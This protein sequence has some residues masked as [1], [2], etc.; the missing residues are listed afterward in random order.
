[1]VVVARGRLDDLRDFRVDGAVRHPLQGLLH[2]APRL[3]PL[4]EAYEVTVVRVAVLADGHLEVHVCVGGVRPRLAYVPSDARAPKRGA[5]EPDCNR[6]RGGDDADADRAP[7][8]DA[9]LGE[10]RLVLFEA[11][12]EVVHEVLHVFREALIGVVGHSADAPSVRGEAR[13][14]LLL[15][16]LQNLLAL[17]QRPKQNSERAYVERVSGEPEEVRGDSVKL[18]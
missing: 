6:V 12:R 17:A 15:E 11:V 8:P 14:E 3:S 1:M 16:Y 10:Q 5:G 2:D 7:E 13:A 4:F 9:V 18:R